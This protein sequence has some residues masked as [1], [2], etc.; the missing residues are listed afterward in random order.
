M[1]IELLAPIIGGLVAIAANI[2][3]HYIK[4]KF[5]PEKPKTYGERLKELV[6]QLSDATNNVD[7]ILSE[8]ANVAKEREDAINKL[9]TELSDLEGKEKA[10]KEK[11]E[12]LSKTPLPVAQHFAELMRSS[13]KQSA[14]RDYMLFGAGVVVST[15]IA[16][17]LKLFGWG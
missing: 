7:K 9:E 2:F 17:A 11:I 1:S 3:T 4:R 6:G 16:I 13:E 14:K 10:M 15:V 8:V 12:V 5:S